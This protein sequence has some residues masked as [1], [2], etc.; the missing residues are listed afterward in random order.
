M[1]IVLVVAI[2]P[3]SPLLWCDYDNHNDK[4]NDDDVDVDDDNDREGWTVTRGGTSLQSCH[5]IKSRT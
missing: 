3:V 2:A 1:V 5:G 4:D